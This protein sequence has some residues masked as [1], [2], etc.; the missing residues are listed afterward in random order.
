MEEYLDLGPPPKKKNPFVALGILGAVALGG[1]GFMLYG[2]ASDGERMNANQQAEEQKNVL[3]LPK[4]EQLAKWRL[5]AADDSKDLLQE[6][7]LK[8]L[9][10]AQDP[11]GIDLAI[12]ALS[13]P[14]QKIRA[15]AATVLAYYGA[16]DA[17]KAIPHLQK[18]LAEAATESRPA[19]AWALVELNDSASFDRV[20][21]IFR[22]GE[23]GFAQRLGGGLAYDPEKLAALVDVEKIAAMYKDDNAGVRQFVASILSQEP[24]SQHLEP[25]LALLDDSREEVS[26]LAAAGLGKIASDQARQP[27][28]SKLR[29]Q[30]TEQRQAYLEA[31]RDGVGTAG[32]VMALDT[33]DTDDKNK[34]WARTDQ[35]FKMIEELADP[36]GGDALAAYLK[37]NPHPH[38][39]FRA[40]RAL[41][42]IGDLRG[43]STFAFRLRADEQRIYSDATDGE[44]LLKRNNNERAEAARML[45]D[46]ALLH[47]EAHE[48][49]R[50]DSEDALIFYL[51]DNLAPHANGLRALAQMEST[52]YMDDLRKW[53][54]PT[55]PLPLEGQQPPMPR[56]WEIAQSAL[57][58]I[59][60][61]KQDRD[62]ANL[63]KQFSRRPAKLDVTM[64]ALLEGGAS[65]L[66]M[67]LRAVGVGA[68]HGLAE[69]GDPK[70]FAALTKY[71]EE[72]LDNDQSRMVACESLAWVASD[73][74]MA[75]VAE[76]IQKYSGAEKAD[77]FRRECF[78]A[79]LV[80]R[81]I[82]GTSTALLSLMTPEASM[83]VK[84]QV[85]RAIGKAGVNEQIEGKLFEMLKDDRVN[86]YA[87]L[88]LMLGGS[89]DVASRT[90]AA[91]A[92]V[93][94]ESIEELQKLWYNTFGYWSREELDQG[95][96]YR[97]IDNAVA[98]SHV[99]IDK[100][101]QDWPTI[102]LKRQL[103]LLQF[104]NGPHSFTRVVLRSRLNEM[105][106]GSDEKL[107][108]GAIRALLFMS[109]R[110]SLMALRSVDGETGKL[111]SEAFHELL[112]PR[113]T[114]GAVSIEK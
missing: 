46:L 94:N 99:E 14:E 19:I 61:A 3:M 21:E 60:L 79:T 95:L 32:L 66:G 83:N 1:V 50:D 7:A 65:L 38:W 111:A 69:W 20:M 85:A 73:E 18:A 114:S 89:T 78:L 100:M 72:P 8:Q 53:S 59:G 47:P 10:W 42:S 41:A 109:E 31:L 56:E 102:Q 15:Q 33:I 5:Y 34:A 37:T 12:N 58:Y 23:I 30:S 26:K 13:N 87:A 67:V 62:W 52:K 88:A 82:E 25:L 110:G 64:D 39:A 70:A 36:N 98:M 93:P 28:L 77:Q 106:R 104:D 107:R 81:P 113:A 80:R 105:A 44:L 74:Q 51:H 90:I 84:A 103:D 49:L 29:G 54:F 57:R 9:A 35:V 97:Y 11:A 68:A 4:E 91:L 40:A 76:K 2:T 48:Q 22:N 6:Q 45:A 71:I 17:S 16:P 27:L 75:E 24:K 112:Y 108:A 96:L 86:I 43:A 92:G 63:E 55:D 101:T